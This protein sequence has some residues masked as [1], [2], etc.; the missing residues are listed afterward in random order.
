MIDTLQLEYGCFRLKQL[1]KKATIEMADPERLVYRLFGEELKTVNKGWGVCY[2]LFIACSWI[3]TLCLCVSVMQRREQL[4]PSQSVLVLHQYANDISWVSGN[5][6]EIHVGHLLMVQ[7]TT[8]GQTR[9]TLCPHCWEPVWSS[10]PGWTW[11]LQS[12]RHPPAT[13]NQP[14]KH[15]L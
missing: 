7:D 5:K 8:E 1:G 4:R 13:A 3:L 9:A 6:D 10:P 12:C 15:R 2:S 11:S 14:Y